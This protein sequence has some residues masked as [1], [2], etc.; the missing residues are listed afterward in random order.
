M[1]HGLP[2]W[3]MGGQVAL[4]AHDAKKL[5]HMLKMRWTLSW[6]RHRHRYRAINIGISASDFD[7]CMPHK[8]C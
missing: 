6:Y 7:C 2:M 8:R 3:H 4:K 1:Q 5:T